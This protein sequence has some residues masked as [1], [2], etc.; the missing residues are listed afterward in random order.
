MLRPNLRNRTFDWMG[1][2][3]GPLVDPHHFLGRSPFD[4]SW[5]LDKKKPA[6]N[7][8]KN[9]ELFEM[10]VA[11]P[12]FAKEDIE[13]TVKDDIL[14]IRGEKKTMEKETESDFVIKGFSTDSFERKFKLGKGI[15][16]EKIKAKYE[17]GVLTLTFIDVPTEKEKWYKKVEVS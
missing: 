9:G 8:K 3:W 17:N 7:V 15:G 11:V 16:H 2:S 12:G 1:E 6:V 10:Q 5:H 13:I 4:I 14:T